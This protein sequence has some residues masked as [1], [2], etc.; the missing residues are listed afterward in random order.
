MRSGRMLARGER[1]N[2]PQARLMLAW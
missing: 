2:R 1:I